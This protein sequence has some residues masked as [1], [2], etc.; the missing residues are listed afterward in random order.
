MERRPVIPPELRRRLWPY[1]DGVARENGIKTLSVGVV[2]DH[3]PGGI[4]R[5]TEE[6]WS[7]L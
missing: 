7:G 4:R 6:A 1:L 5:V 2:E 3:V